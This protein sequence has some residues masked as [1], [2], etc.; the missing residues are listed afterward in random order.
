[1]EYELLNI[2]ELETKHNQTLESISEDGVSIPETEK[3]E[4]KNTA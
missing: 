3:E 4:M 2:T 1:M